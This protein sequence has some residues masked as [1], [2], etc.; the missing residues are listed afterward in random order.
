MWESACK[1]DTTTHTSKPV[2]TSSLL[3]L[4]SQKYA[5]LRMQRL[6]RYDE[7]APEYR[8]LRMGY[9]RH[10]E[11]VILVVLAIIEKNHYSR[12]KRCYM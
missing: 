11:C 9:V 12:G 10:Q 2:G 8:E 3:I 4:L 1:N 7:C 5:K 6:V